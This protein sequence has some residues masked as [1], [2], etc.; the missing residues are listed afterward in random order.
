MHHFVDNTLILLIVCLFF[1]DMFTEKEVQYFVLD[2]EVAQKTTLLM[3]QFKE[4]VAPFLSL[5]VH[6]FLSLILIFPQISLALADGNLSFWEEVKL[7]RKARKASKG[8]FF[9]S[10]DPV[11]DSVKYIV[12]S[13]QKW[14]DRFCEHIRFVFER[15]VGSEDLRFLNDPSLTYEQKLMKSPYILTRYTSAMFFDRDE[16]VLNPTSVKAAEL[17]KIKVIGTKTGLSAYAFFT[18]F[19]ERFNK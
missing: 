1:V 10:K 19:V 4:E 18:E 12:K 8:G 17:E 16:D 15:F 2:P 5:S 3:G 14:E 7:Q 9:L 13:H 11:A 6:D